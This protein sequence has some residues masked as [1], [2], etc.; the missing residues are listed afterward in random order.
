MKIEAFCEGICDQCGAQRKGVRFSERLSVAFLCWEHFQPVAVALGKPR[1]PL[2]REVIVYRSHSGCHYDGCC[3]HCRK[4][5]STVSWCC[6]CPCCTGYVTYGR[7]ISRGY[8]ESVGIGRGETEGRSVTH[9]EGRS[10]GESKRSS[11]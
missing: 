9:T 11:S 4:R 5:R 8:S 10:R 2:E 3:G 6:S 1:A 7:S